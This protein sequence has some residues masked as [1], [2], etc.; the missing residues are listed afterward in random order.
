MLANPAIAL[1]DYA[2]ALEAFLFAL[3]LVR[4]GRIERTWAIAFLS[5]GMAAGLGGTVHGFVEVLSLRAQILLWQGVSVSLAVAGTAMILA[6][7][8]D[9]LSGL[10]RRWME[11]IA[12]LKLG[13]IIPPALLLL[14]FA[15]SVADYLISMLLVLAVRQGFHLKP[16]SPEAFWT[17]MGVGLSAIAALPLLLVNVF[18]INIFPIDSAWFHPEVQYH[19]IQMV[20]LYGFFRAACH[21]RVQG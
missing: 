7:V 15:W 17:G 14:S 21:R 11:A 19:L 8:W 9:R 20:A 5:T 13:I 1:T 18:Q 4:F 16:V 2:I 6:T 12:L 3:W 10:S